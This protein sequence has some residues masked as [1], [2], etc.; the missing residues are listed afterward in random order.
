[1]ALLTLPSVHPVLGA[2]EP[3]TERNRFSGKLSVGGREITV[4]LKPDKGGDFTSSEASA[5]RFAA[6]AQTE[7][8]AVSEFLADLYLERLNGEW[9][10]PGQRVVSY[11]KFRATLKPELVTFE[12]DGTAE[13]MCDSGKLFEGHCL[14]ARSHPNAVIFDAELAG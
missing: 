8:D 5:I 14:I 1:M 12:G 3:N 7:M 4:R 9:R 10:L 13:F 11:A 6:N 2:L